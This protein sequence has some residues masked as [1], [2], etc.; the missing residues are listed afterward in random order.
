MNRKK[1]KHCREYFR[2]EKP[3]QHYCLKEECVKEWLRSLKEK[4]WKARKKELQE[5]LKTVQDLLKETQVVFNAY[6]RERDKGK[7][8]IS[9]GNSKPKKVNAGHYYSS[10]GHKAVTFD[11]SNVHLQCEHCNTFLSGN[12]IEYRKR[13]IERIG[14]SE[15]ERLEKVAQNERKYTREE[16]REIK[17]KY[18]QK[19]KD[20]RIK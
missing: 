20:L 3:L 7:P 18:K 8:C 9:C 5:D 15:V 19:I 16:L 12:L 13:L 4:Q 6:I 2:P 11:E 10:G 1:C 14:I 17:E